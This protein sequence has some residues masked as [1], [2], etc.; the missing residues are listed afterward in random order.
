MK[1]RILKT[2]NGLG[3]ITYRPQYRISYMNFAV[4]ADNPFI[5]TRILAFIV[6]H[7]FLFWGIIPL[8]IQNRWDDIE[9]HNKSTFEILCDFFGDKIETITD[10]DKAKKIV[11]VFIAEHN[12]K[13]K[14]RLE[15]LQNERLK[16]RVK[17]TIIKHP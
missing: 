1:T 12:D 10:L 14:K 8:Y 5:A 17:R 9:F 3:E 15:S 4:G 16:K 11:D 13:E 2:E 7:A 6:G